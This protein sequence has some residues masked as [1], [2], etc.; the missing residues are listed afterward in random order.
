MLSLCIL[1][2]DALDPDAREAHLKARETHI[3]EVR[4]NFLRRRRAEQQAEENVEGK[5]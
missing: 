3:N 4:A 5:G 2:S 1:L